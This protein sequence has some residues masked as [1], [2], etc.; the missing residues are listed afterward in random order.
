M[1]ND[2]YKVVIGMSVMKEGAEDFFDGGLVYHNLPE[3]MLVQLEA[4]F[5]KNASGMVAAMEPMVDELVRMGVEKAERNL[6]NV[7]NQTGNT[8]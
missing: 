2:K 8:R 5:A 1:S 6:G 4:V 3:D 7:P